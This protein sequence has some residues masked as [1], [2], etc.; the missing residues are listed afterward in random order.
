MTLVRQGKTGPKARQRVAGGASP[1]WNRRRPPEPRG[2]DP[3]PSKS[4]FAPPG[5]LLDTRIHPGAHAP[6]YPL[7]LPRSSSLRST[8]IPRDTSRRKALGRTGTVTYS[9]AGSPLLPV[10]LCLSSGA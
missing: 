4:T 7:S 5:L 6:G 10:A 2:G 3:D 9:S 1:R 8:A